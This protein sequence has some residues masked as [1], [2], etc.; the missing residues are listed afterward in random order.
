MWLFV[1]LLAKEHEC[2]GECWDGINIMHMHV[3]KRRDYAFKLYWLVVLI[4][5]N[6]TIEHFDL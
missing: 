2:M 1:N 5:L 4:L 6:T 3:G